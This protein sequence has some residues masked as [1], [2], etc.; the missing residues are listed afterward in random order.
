MKDCKEHEKMLWE[1]F[2]E[3][4]RLF[5]NNLKTIAEFTTDGPFTAAIGRNCPPR[6]AMWMGWQI[7]RSYMKN[8]PKISLD[9]L[10]MQKDPQIILSK[11]KYRP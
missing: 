4:N 6:I 9:E 8:N 10:M 2:A 7:V 1:F 5:E 11:S 3:K